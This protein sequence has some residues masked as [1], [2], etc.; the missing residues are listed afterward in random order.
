MSDAPPSS[1]DHIPFDDRELK[2]LRSLTRTLRAV[3]WLHISLGGAAALV[4]LLIAAATASHT[5]DGPRLA[6]ALSL[7]LGAGLIGGLTIAQ[8]RLLHRA[9]ARLTL[10]IET[11]E[12]DQAHLAYA[13]A[14][15]ASFFICEAL[16]AALATLLTWQ[17]ILALLERITEAP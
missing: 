10:V 14:R 4:I 17:A 7:I 1:L 5:T 8:G 9:R 6:L 2:R 16:Y 13:L 12:A 11:D 3:G 15:L